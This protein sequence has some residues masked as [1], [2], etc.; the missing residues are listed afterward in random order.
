MKTLLVLLFFFLTA[1][2]AFS[3]L[4]PYNWR[5]GISGGYTN[6]YGDLSPHRIS[7]V[8]DLSNLLRLFNYN[9]NYVTDYSYTLSLE[10]AL[11]ATLGLQ[12]SVGKYSISMSD[13][14]IS[15]SNVLQLDSPNFMRSL[16][17]KT[18]IMDYGVGLVIK[19]D[20]GKLVKKNAFIAPYLT[21]G[22]GWLNFK[23]FG[24][25]YDDN[26]NPYD[27]SRPENVNNGIFETRLDRLNTETDEGYANN[28][29][30]GQFGFGIRFRVAKQ[31]ELFAQSDF[32]L[33]NTDYLDDVSGGY[34]QAYD[35][36]EQQYAA[37]PNPEWDYSVRGNG[38][39]R[40]DWYIN[41]RVGIK[42]SFSPRKA[43]FAAP[44]VN[45]GY[46]SQTAD[47][48]AAINPTLTPIDSLSLS[49]K[50]EQI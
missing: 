23:V 10:R 50:Q 28:A 6:Y 4:D 48:P 47:T 17:F 30:Y 16:N 40:N 32:K 9:E 46:Y 24:D 18:E 19:A 43:A 20:N 21:L 12:L 35:S 5:V 39:G 37:R 49:D 8:D 27:Y 2:S 38:N 45:P 31:L 44:R 13:R 15:P 26:D 29:F 22:M 34:R 41:H 3:Q 11:N 14:Y 1:H 33:A 25:L 36:P 7:S 42:L